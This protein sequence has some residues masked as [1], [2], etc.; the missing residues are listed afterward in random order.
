[1]SAAQGHLGTNRVTLGRTNAVIYKLMQI[2]EEGMGIERKRKGRK[3]EE[4]REEEEGKRR[5]RKQET[6]TKK[7]K[8]RE[9]VK[10]N[11]RRS[12]LVGAL[13]LVN[14]RGLHQC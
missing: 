12:L 7:K 3:Q 14:H 4:K 11:R 10:S 6:K 2:Q 9:E 13:S 5:S 1:M 8:A